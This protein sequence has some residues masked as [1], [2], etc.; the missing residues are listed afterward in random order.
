MDQSK[1]REGHCGSSVLFE[2]M[3][4]SGTL[5]VQHNHPISMLPNLLVSKDRPENNADPPLST[6]LT[7][8]GLPTDI[9]LCILDF[10]HK[11]D[12]TC[13][14]LTNHH[15]YAIHR[16]RHGSVSLSAR[17]G[18]RLADPCHICREACELRLHLERWMPRG[19]E[20]CAIS[21]KYG[22]PAS[23]FSQS[24]CSKRCPKNSSLCGRH[25]PRI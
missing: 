18:R 15:F 10:L 7:F 2:S 13:L 23:T 6:S 17:Q 11:V 22:R 21:E 8:S 19:M 3:H 1:K 4:N 16:K 14:G 20:Y 24:Y 5:S 9:H 25:H 12:S